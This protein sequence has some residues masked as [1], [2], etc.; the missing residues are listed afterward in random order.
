MRKRESIAALLALILLT[1]AGEAPAALGGEAGAVDAD[2]FGP[3]ARR[4]V[5]SQQRYTVEEVQLPSG[6]VVREYVSASGKVFAVTWKGP[7]MPDLEQILGEHFA[8]YRIAAKAGRKGRGQR[9]VED[10]G[11]VVQSGGHMRAFA[12]RAFL[13]HRLPEGVSPDELE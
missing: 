1:P 5:L 11:L 7:H 8:A 9:T 2:R 3:Q 12:G 4:R 6:T 13:R 10:A